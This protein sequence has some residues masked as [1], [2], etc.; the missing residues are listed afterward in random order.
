M[1]FVGFPVHTLP[2]L[3]GPSPWQIT[4]I[5][6]FQKMLSKEKEISHK[7]RPQ[8]SMGSINRSPLLLLKE[9]L[10]KHDGDTEGKD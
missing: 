9:S 2:L 8:G 6:L 7:P 4:D 5:Q 1:P 10:R 3:P